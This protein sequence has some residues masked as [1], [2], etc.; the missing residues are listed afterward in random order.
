LGH[1]DHP[2]LKLLNTVLGGSMSSRLFIEVREKRSLAYQVGSVYNAYRGPSYLG[3]YLGTTPA[4]FQQARDTVEA[5]L[6]RVARVP[7][8]EDE[9]EASRKYLRGSTLLAQETNRARATRYA[10]YEALDLGFDYGDRVLA[11]ALATTAE[12]A[13][14]AAAR[15]F[16]RWVTAAVMP[17]PDRA[18]AAASPTEVSASS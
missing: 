2:A 8:A 16:N 17:A 1:P 6:R 14:A 5:E 13:M 18:S 3:G 7:V 9:L 4:Q 10:M 11:A 12:Q 15:H